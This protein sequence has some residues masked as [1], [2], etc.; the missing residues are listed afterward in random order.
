MST[1]FH[2]S[3]DE[4]EVARVYWSLVRR[5]LSNGADWFPSHMSTVEARPESNLREAEIVVSVRTVD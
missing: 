4:V 2:L 5:G 1:E 3:P